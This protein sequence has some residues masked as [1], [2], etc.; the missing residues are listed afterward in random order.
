M[1]M[2]HFFY[3]Y[4]TSNV[5]NML[6]LSLVFN[7]ILEGKASQVNIIVGENIYN[8]CYGPFLGLGVRVVI[9]FLLEGV[10]KNNLEIWG[11]ML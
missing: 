10:C 6:E 1:V 7:D 11:V 8:M 4:E 9:F 3:V 5:I 2:A